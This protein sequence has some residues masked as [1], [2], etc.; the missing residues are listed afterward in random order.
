METLLVA[1][2]HEDR[3]QVSV[4]A[5]HEFRV[6]I[7]SSAGEALPTLCDAALDGVVCCVDYHDGDPFQFLELV[8]KQPGCASL[9]FMVVREVEGRLSSERYR[10]IETTCAQRGIPYFDGAAFVR[11][12]GAE[13]G[14]AQ[15]RQLIKDFLKQKR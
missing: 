4:I 8:R 13:A 15:L 12:R 3:D 14:H 7:V 2:R 9:P 10:S 11:Q 1:V 5:A 6:Y